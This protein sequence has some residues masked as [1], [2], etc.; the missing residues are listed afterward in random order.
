M[1]KRLLILILTL[2]FSNCDS[3][4]DSIGDFNEVVIVSSVADKELIYPYIN[5][6]FSKYI[7]TPIE[8]EVF[9]I[10][11]IDAQDFFKYKY[12]NNIVII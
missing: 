10:K 1:P 11:W 6:I 8:E 12:H 5:P 3:K 7:N 2:F 9:K 4:K